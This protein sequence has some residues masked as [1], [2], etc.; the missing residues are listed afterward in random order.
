M[1]ACVETYLVTKDIQSGKWSPVRMA[2]REFILP[3]E[4]V[5][6]QLPNGTERIGV[7]MTTEFDV[8]GEAFGAFAKMWN[9]SPGMIGTATAVMTKREFSRQDEP[10]MDMSVPELE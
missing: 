10:E 7:A 6:Q 2:R 9:I 3:G 1:E 8:T 4:Y 5:V